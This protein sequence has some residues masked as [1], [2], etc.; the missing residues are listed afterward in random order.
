MRILTPKT[1]A[2]F[3]PLLLAGMT[4]QSAGA[5]TP[6]GPATWGNPDQQRGTRRAVT[7][8]DRALIARYRS[9]RAAAFSTGFNN[10]GEFRSQWLVQ[11]D[12][13]SDL[14]SCRQPASVAVSPT[15]LT[16]KTLNATGCHAR[17]STGS[18]LSKA[19]YSFGLFEASIKIADIGGMNNAFWLTTDDK[20]EIDIAE[21]HYPNDV[22]ITLHNNNNW[23][24]DPSHAVGFDRK[25]ADNFS[26]GYHDFGVLWTARDMIFEIDGEPVAAIDTEGSVKGPA[27][28]RFSTALGNF[29]GAIPDNPACA[30][31]ESA[32][33]ATGTRRS[34]RHIPPRRPARSSQIGRRCDIQ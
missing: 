17:Y 12:D 19:K 20:F 32:L 16:L 8:A 22:R 1:I 27:T 4:M 2:R 13:R 33:S 25:F 14:K 11:L 26:A 5:A 15:G 28:V 3:L 34:H 30:V 31:A 24:P 29:G 23:S 6:L 7:P 10:D 21:V 9:G 18:V